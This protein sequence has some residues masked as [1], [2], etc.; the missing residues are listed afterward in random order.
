MAAIRISYRASY[1]VSVG[2]SGPPRAGGMHR[3]TILSCHDTSSDAGVAIASVHAGTKIIVGETAHAPPPRVPPRVPFPYPPPGVPAAPSLTPQPRRRPPSPGRQ[4][5]G[6]WDAGSWRRRGRSEI[7]ARFLVAG[8][9]VVR[10][11]GGVPTSASPGLPLSVHICIIFI[12][13]SATATV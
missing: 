11:V 8:P 3:S 4:V 9:R 6:S 13:V 10:G 1:S 12:F 7:A 2:R 5:A